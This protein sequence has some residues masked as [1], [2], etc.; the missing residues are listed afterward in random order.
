M[1]SS[2]PE[3]LLYQLLPVGASALADDAAPDWLV[4]L[5]ADFARAGA[6][7][8]VAELVDMAYRDLVA[9]G[10]QDIVDTHNYGLY[11]LL[12]DCRDVITLKYA[13]LT[14]TA[15]GSER[16]RN[17][18]L[19]RAYRIVHSVISVILEWQQLFAPGA[20]WVIAVTGLDRTQHL[21]R[22][23][24]SELARR[25]G[26]RQQHIAVLAALA[27]DR[28]ALVAQGGDILLPTAHTL[29]S[30]ATQCAVHTGTPADGAAWN[31]DDTR[32]ND[33]N[34]WEKIYTGKL[35]WNLAAGDTRAVADT[36]LRTLCMYNHYGYYHEASSFAAMV[37]PHLDTLG[38]DQETHWNYIGNVVQSHIASGQAQRGLEILLA[39]APALLDE[40]A[41]LAKM[42]YL[43]AML[44]LRFLD[45]KDIGLAEH[46]L[47]AALDCLEQA[48]AVLPDH[49]FIFLN[50]FLNNGL[51]FLRVRQGR[52][53]EA[54]HLCLHGFAL[55]TAAVG[56]E[57]HKLHRSVLLYNSAQV[58]MALGQLD[59]ALK[60]YRESIAMDPH[61]S[62]Y[63]NEIGNILQQQGKFD[64]ALPA[65]A[66]AIQYSAPYPEVYFNKGVS[67]A[68]LGQ[69]DDALAALDFSAELD[70]AQPEL[71]LLRAE[72][73][74]ALGQ[75]D[76][77]VCDYTAALAAG[78]RSIIARVNRAVL[79]FQSG[80]FEQ[81]LLDMHQ[82]IQQEPDNASHYENR[83]EIYR[84]MRQP[85]L[86]CADLDAAI[87]YREAA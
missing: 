77:A 78:S 81:A 68:Q 74:E 54:A 28:A 50:V 11:M 23:F 6:W 7:S 34:V 49:E 83:A 35:A 22:R 24:F 20:R 12:P 76:A 15:R 62:E 55:L 84:A 1:E 57:T 33:M 27:P 75:A 70:P 48:R 29:Q 59:D 5:H 2:T 44:H 32:Q 79:Y 38:A 37:L 39:F 41:L 21:A 30:L 72:V 82:A 18:P 3:L 16:T 51:A 66:L 10:R 36:A 13:S 45:N 31:G 14:D 9:R 43:V 58:F 64:E 85:A 17:F 4:T 42:H 87:R 86:V 56:D 60:Y 61:Y 73:R 47:L 69:W 46:H 8:G 80:Q 25:A 67:H 71:Y 63:H 26:S 65:Y 19:D 40:P 52:R 53:A